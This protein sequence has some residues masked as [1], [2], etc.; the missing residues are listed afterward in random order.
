VVG[1]KKSVMP[2][3]EKLGYDII[4]LDAEANKL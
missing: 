3:L 2:G 4:E 1:D